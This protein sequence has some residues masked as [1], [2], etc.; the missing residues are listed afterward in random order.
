MSNKILL[1]VI[2]NPIKH[3]L[4]PQIHQQFAEQFG[5]VIDYQKYL[6]EAENLTSFIENFFTQG[7]VGLNV[8]LP[9]KQH[10][11]PLVDQ[12]T[13]EARLAQSVNTLYK[14]TAG[15]LVGH[16]TDGQGVLLDLEQHGFAVE[17]KKLLV[18]GAGGASQSILV[19]LLKSGAEIR[20]LNRSQDKVT[21]LVE[22]LQSVGNIQAFSE[23]EK[24]D[25]VISTISEFN[26]SLLAP[27]AACIDANTFCYDLN[28]AARAQAFYAFAKQSGCLRFADGLGM[29]LGQAAHAYQIWLGKLPDINRVKIAS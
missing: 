28:Y 25:G 11:I 24:F 9:H 10:V 20:L 7:G 29:L 1:G 16:T 23:I 15:Q 13:D 5:H 14:N 4:S 3:S 26:A 21:R 27:V 12:L 8:T 18:I 19:S 6:V 22:R 17:R 2:G